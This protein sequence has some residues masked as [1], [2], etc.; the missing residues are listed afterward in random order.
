MLMIW[1]ITVAHAI[2]A[3]P[4]VGSGP[5]PYTSAGLSTQLSRKPRM[6]TLLY[7]RV[8]P[9]A[10]RIALRINVAIKKKVPL[11]MIFMYVNAS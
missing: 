2:P 7:V 1:I 3:S 4:S 8:S 5:H 10:L 6:S 11:K 9:V